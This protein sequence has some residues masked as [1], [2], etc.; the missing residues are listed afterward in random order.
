MKILKLMRSNPKVVSPDSSLTEAA[1]IMK[2]INAGVLPVVE[3]KQVIGMVTD[4]DI[5]VRAV[6]RGQDPNTLT[7][8]DVMT[9]QAICC[10]DDE[11]IHVAGQKM[12]E[13]HVGRLPVLSRKNMK[14]AGIITLAD[15][16]TEC[17]GKAIVEGRNGMS[18]KVKYGVPAAL[19]ALAAFGAYAY[20]HR[21][22]QAA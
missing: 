14:L 2:T 5:T 17:G 11:D 8:R 18:P 9:S 16:I 13:S 1:D 3:N 4:R 19:A 6:A 10:Y 15:I 12:M 21:P 7:V 22:A 20:S